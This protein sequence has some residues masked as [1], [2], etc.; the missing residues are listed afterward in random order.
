MPTSILEDSTFWV[1][2]SFIIFIFVDHKTSERI[3]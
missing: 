3:F 2:S 1:A